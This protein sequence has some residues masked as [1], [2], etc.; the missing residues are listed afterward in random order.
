MPGTGTAKEESRMAVI[1]GQDIVNFARANLGK[2]TCSTNSLGG[3]GF[4][5]SCKSNGG[6]P[7]YWCADFAKWVWK[8]SRVE[9]LAGLT[10]AAHSFYT[11]GI[12]RRT[13]SVTPQ[14]STVAL[15][16]NRNGDATSD[17]G[18]IHHVAIVSQVNVDGTI[19]A[20]SG[21]GNGVDTAQRSGVLPL[22]TRRLASLLRESRRIHDQHPA[23]V[24][25]TLHRVP[26]QDV[27]Q[28]VRAPWCQVQEPLHPFR[29]GRPGVLSDRPAVLLLQRR[30]KTAQ[31]RLGL[32]LRLRTAEQRRIAHPT[33]RGPPRSPRH[34]PRRL[35]PQA[36]SSWQPIMPPHTANQQI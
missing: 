32:P 6:S 27:P 23:L 7:Q 16:S 15:F 28:P 18:G 4:E 13:L 2:G 33:P 26:D 30:Q 21:G 8:N 25:E 31:I 1:N 35:A 34:P 24:R 22:D 29:R 17:G 11:Y 20:I 36:T 9:D 19:E 5:T 10:P 12:D 14:I 3:T